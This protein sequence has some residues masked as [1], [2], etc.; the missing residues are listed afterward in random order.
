MPKD[1]ILFKEDQGQ[2][3]AQVQKMLGDGRVALASCDGVTRTGLIRGSMRRRGRRVW[4]NTG[5][6]VLIS[7]RDF[8]PA[9]AD[10]IH[11]YSAH[12]ARILQAYGELPPNTKIN[13]TAIDVIL[14]GGDAPDDFNFDFQEI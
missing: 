9:K 11:K 8:Q 10:I 12:E 1:E 13:P 5:D 14:E 7:L 2:E 3:Y 4:I 6:I